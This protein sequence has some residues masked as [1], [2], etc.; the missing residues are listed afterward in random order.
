MAI[1]IIARDRYVLSRFEE[2]SIRY[3]FSEPNSQAIGHVYPPRLYQQRP[4]A[5]ISTAINLAR[6]TVGPWDVK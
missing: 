5:L 4:F 6:R 1:E 2:R 3:R